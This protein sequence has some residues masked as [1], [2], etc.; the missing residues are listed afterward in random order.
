MQNLTTYYAATIQT[1]SAFYASMAKAR[2]SFIDT[3]D[4]GEFVAQL[5]SAAG[6]E[7]KVY[8]LNGPEAVTYDEVAERIS[9]LTGRSVRYVDIPPAQLR[10]SMLGIGMPEWQADA[11]LELQ[12]YYTEGGGGDVDDLFRRVVGR[13]P[14]RLDAFLREFSGEF[15]AQA[16]SA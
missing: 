11:L 13:E 6:H 7:G 1:Q 2:V 3:R 12:R 10:Q 9:R 15:A 14:R 8:D 16:A 5:F 4:I